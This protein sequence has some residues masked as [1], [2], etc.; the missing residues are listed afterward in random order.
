MSD[1]LKEVQALW[2]RA[3]E[4]GAIDLRDDRPD[5]CLTVIL[6]Y[7]IPDCWKAEGKL[8]GFQI[9]DLVVAGE[10]GALKSVERKGEI[11]LGQ[12]RKLGHRITLKMPRKWKDGGW[13]HGEEAEGLSF[14]S[15]LRV[16]GRT[17]VNERAITVS[18]WS[19]P[20]AGARDYMRVVE[21]MH[22]NVLNIW[23]RKRF[24]RIVSAASGGFGLNLNLGRLWMVWIG[25][26]FL[27]AILKAVVPR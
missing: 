22:T 27:A 13:H 14:V 23:A 19:M 10:L 20:A 18:S 16:E 7:E 3:H 5:N 1:R 9:H 17:L 25:I 21:A 6:R 2:P 8:L 12:P 15:R 11:V 26:M 4:T 24:G